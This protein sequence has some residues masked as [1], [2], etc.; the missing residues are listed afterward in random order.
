MIRFNRLKLDGLSSKFGG[1]SG[2]SCRLSFCRFKVSFVH[3][4]D[5]DDGADGRDQEHDVKPTVVKIKLKT[6]TG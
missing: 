2:K 5:D 1:L 6:K 3:H 4:D